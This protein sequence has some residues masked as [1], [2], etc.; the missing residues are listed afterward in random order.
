MLVEVRGQLVSALFLPCG[1]TG[2]NSD[3]TPSPGLN[4]HQAQMV[5]THGK[6]LILIPL[7]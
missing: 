7:K 3:L 6:T 1:T 5:H 2:S 4:R